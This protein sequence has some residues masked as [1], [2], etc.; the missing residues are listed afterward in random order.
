MIHDNHGWTGTRYTRTL[1]AAEGTYEAIVYSNVEAPKEGRMFGNAE[2]GTGNT[3]AFEY[4]LDAMGRLTEDEADGVGGSGNAFVAARV[5]L[6]GVTRTAGT[7][8]S[9]CRVRTRTT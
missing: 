8:T 5:A 6:T 9:G 7:E 2:P 4:D 3:R 1:P